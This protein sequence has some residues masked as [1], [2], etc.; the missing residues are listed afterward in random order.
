MI[1]DGRLSAKPVRGGWIN[2]YTGRLVESQHWGPVALQ[3]PSQGLLVRLWTARVDDKDVLISAEGVAEVVLYSHSARLTAVSLAF[4]QNGDPH[5]TLID[6]N[7]TAWLRW[8]D[9]TLPGMAMTALPAD[10]LYPILTFDDARQFAVDS[11]DVILSY[12]RADVLRYRIQRERFL[13]EHTPPVGEGGAPL[14]VAGKPLLHVSM[15]AKQR[16]QWTFLNTDNWAMNPAHVLYYARTHPEIG[17]EP[18]ANM[19]DA[20]YRAAADKLYE[21]GFGICTSY[22]P[23]AESLEEF[24]GRICRLIGGSVSRDLVDGQYYLD[25][26]RGDYDVDDLPVVTD[27]DIIS[28]EAQPSTLDGAVNSVS[29]KYFDPCRRE[30]VMTPSVQ[31]L[32]LIDAF[33]VIHQTMEYPEI[34]SGALALIVAER[35]VRTT[36]TPTIPFNLVVMPDAVRAIRPNRHFRL[37]APKHGIEDMVCLLGEK[38]AGTLKSGAMRIKATQDIY[39][40]PQTSFVEVE[41]GVDTRP[42]PTPYPITQQAALEAPYIELVQRLDRANLDVLPADAG[43]LLVVADRPQQGGHNYNVAVAAGGAD[44]AGEATGDWCPVAVVAGDPAVDEIDQL[45]TVIPIADF[46]RAEQLTMGSAALWDGEI[47]RIDAVDVLAGTVTVGRACAD[48]I[49]TRHAAGSHIWAYDDAAASDL[50]EYAEGEIIGIKLLTNTGTA[51]LDPAEATPMS[52]EFAGRAARPYP[53]AAV[54]IN[55]LAWPAEIADT[56]QVTWV[57]RDRLAQADKLVDQALPSIGPE[58]GVTYTVRWYLDDVLVNTAES[59]AGDSASF[60]PAAA[61]TL[62]IEIES[63]RGGLV[64]LQLWQHT[65]AYTPPPPPEE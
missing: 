1:P 17:R 51:R 54:R 60:V 36:A 11:S 46:V 23:S 22:D 63:V 20:S 48:T 50:V 5:L 44:Y 10:H 18:K 12:V 9:P 14:A 8:Y 62:R 31:A 30:D 4:N 27:D 49:P 15:N 47:V 29:V 6:T 21:E 26:A 33:G 53:P 57:H 37:Q 34:P 64:C 59:I 40:L 24:E 2:P 52:V 43:Y 28:F 58:A 3:D 16:L 19:N 61:G 25:L 56:A 55:G 42:D 13:V 38:Q 39:S 65:M 45:A 32:G 41:P 35:D 7:G